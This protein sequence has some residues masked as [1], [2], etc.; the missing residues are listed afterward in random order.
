MQARSEG[1]I[2]PA[3]NKWHERYYKWLSGLVVTPK[4]KQYTK[5]LWR[6]Y[7]KPFR[8]ILEKDMN[9]VI[10]GVELRYRFGHE[11]RLPR[12]IVEYELD[13]SDC[14]VLEMMIALSIRCEEN[15]MTNEAEGDR[16][17]KWFWSMVQSLGL[18]QMS[19]GFYDEQKVDDILDRFVKRK[20]EKNGRGGLF[21]IHNQPGMDQ[22][23]V[24]IWYQMM[25][26]LIEQDEKG[27]I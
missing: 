23:K 5:L 7:T 21:T 3:E 18:Y 25:A 10:D 9:R 13:D 4:K 6:L 24:E 26:W 22:R 11:N 27:E 8:Y 2:E 12:D 1:G 14:S 19:D 16:T 20:Y 15:I 17:S